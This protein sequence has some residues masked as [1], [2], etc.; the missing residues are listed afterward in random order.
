[1]RTASAGGAV[2][3]KQAAKASVRSL[4]CAL[5]HQSTLSDFGVLSGVYLDNPKEIGSIFREP[6]GKSR[7]ARCAI[8]S[9]R[10]IQRLPSLHF[11]EVE[12]I[13]LFGATTITTDCI[14]PE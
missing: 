11:A 3:P 10:Q 1:V 8:N 14:S 12:E 9:E 2:K 6:P 4:L 5:C 7:T 13:I